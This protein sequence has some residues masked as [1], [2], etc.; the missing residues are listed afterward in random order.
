MLSMLVGMGMAT[1]RLE[2]MRDLCAFFQR[3]MIGAPERYA[4][5][6]SDVRAVEAG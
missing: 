1:R 3:E 2:T 5:E 6:R 4:T